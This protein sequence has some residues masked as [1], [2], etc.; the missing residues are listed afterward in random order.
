MSWLGG[1]LPTVAKAAGSGFTRSKM[2]PSRVDQFL[3]RFGGPITGGL[4]GS[5]FGPW[6]G[7]AGTLIGGALS[8][9]EAQE[10]RRD[11]DASP[12]EFGLSEGLGSIWNAGAEARKDQSS[13]W[14]ELGL[15]EMAGKTF[16]ADRAAPEDFV[17]GLGSAVGK[18]G[19]AGAIP[20]AGQ[21]GKASWEPMPRGYTGGNT[22]KG[23]SFLQK[24]AAPLI[25]AALGG[26]TGGGWKG[27]LGGG[28]AGLGVGH[29]LNNR[30][31]ATQK[32]LGGAGS[33]AAATAG[34]PAAQAGFSDTERYERML[35]NQQWLKDRGR[36]FDLSLS[37][38][39]R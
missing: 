19:A 16:G 36:P 13:V 6:G 35:N 30:N 20:A 9:K 8:T 1:A 7:A 21:A 29:L 34:S 32:Q 22:S 37:G 11:P 31:A 3:S 38:I 14:P 26:L 25:G 4:L 10:A 5:R 28:L 2:A 39:L 33:W 15:S 17:G 24:W 18:A 27:A 23:K 12:F